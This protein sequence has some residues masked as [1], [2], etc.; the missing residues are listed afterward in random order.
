LLK[1]WK[2]SILSKLYMRTK[3]PQQYETIRI[4]QTVQTE[5]IIAFPRQHPGIVLLTATCWSTTTTTFPWPQWLRD[6]ATIYLYTYTTILSNCSSLVL[7]P[8]SKHV[9]SKGKKAAQLQGWTDPEG[10][11]RLR[12]QDF[13]TMSTWKS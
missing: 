7:Y 12:L 6:H 13:K 8:L 4:S 3:L 10:S 1:T 5:F 11:R 2:I 9:S